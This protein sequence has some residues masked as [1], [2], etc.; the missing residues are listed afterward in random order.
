MAAWEEAGFA[1]FAWAALGS[2]RCVVGQRGE[3]LSVLCLVF[4]T[5]FPAHPQTPMG[6]GRSAG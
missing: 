1:R 2:S 5:S 3:R 4:L 6:G